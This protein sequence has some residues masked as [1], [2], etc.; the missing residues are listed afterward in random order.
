[1]QIQKNK[2]SW[3]KKVILSCGIVFCIVLGVMLITQVFV[4]E[5]FVQEKV[6]QIIEDEFKYINQIGPV[7]FHRP[8]SI[9][10]AYLTVQKQ[11][12]NK[13]SPIR[14]ENIQSTFQL[15]P[16]LSKKIIIKKLSVQQINYENRLLIKDLVTDKFSFIDGVV[17]THARFRVNEG[18]TTM[19][20]IIDLH[21]KKPVFDLSFD[22]KDIHITQD[23]PAIDLLPIFAVKGGEI[24]GLLNATGSLRGKGF[25]KE[26]F[27]EK[28]VADINLDVRDGYIRGNELL[29]SILEIMGGK[30]S[31]S[32]DSMVALIQIKDRKVYTQK[33]DIQ[34]PLMS[35][36]ASGMAEFEGTISYD[37]VVKFNE[38]HL[39]KDAEKIAE[40]VLKQNELPIEIRGTTEDPEV[41]VKLNKENLEN[42]FKGL[43]NEFL[44]T[45]KKGQK[46]D[47]NL[48]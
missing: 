22:A 19:K 41:V 39:G 47:G 3:V 17:S 7:S 24:G 1:M 11:E 23:L 36:N 6:T 27:N 45:S 26:A 32:F 35:L 31:Y 44:R 46:K 15:L 21:Q 8:N 14:F 5:D 29:S 42:V 18:P 13:N 43:V 40:L 37:A 30:N 2:R 34:G 33:M 38:E 10:I 4:S 20:G 16:L 12:Q 28:L 9:T 25:G 48:P